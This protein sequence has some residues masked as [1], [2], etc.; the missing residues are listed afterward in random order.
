MNY[1]FRFRSWITILDSKNERS[2]TKSNNDLNVQSFGILF[3]LVQ[4]TN[5][6]HFLG[7]YFLYGRVIILRLVAEINKFVHFNFNQSNLKE[8][9][10]LPNH[11]ITLKHC[12]KRANDAE[13]ST[14]KIG[15]FPITEVNMHYYLNTWIFIFPNMNTITKAN[16]L[17]QKQ[18]LWNHWLYIKK[19]KKRDT[20]NNIF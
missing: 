5:A 20:C 10:K 4:A 6:W 13:A 11:R 18:I 12:F 19:K 9:R 7:L 16:D 14:K 15:N 8:K 2:Q 17:V 3:V 1:Y